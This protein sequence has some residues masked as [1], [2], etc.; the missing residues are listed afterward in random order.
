MAE[1]IIG[2]TRIVQTYVCHDCK[3]Q[4]C[5]IP[6]YIHGKGEPRKVCSSCVIKYEIME[7][8]PIVTGNTSDIWK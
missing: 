1:R 8:E 5:D 7:D 6:A 4:V 2:R 3:K